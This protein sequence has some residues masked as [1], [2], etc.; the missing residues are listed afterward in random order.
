MP[1]L[2]VEEGGF[3][4][5]LRPSGQHGLEVVDAFTELQVYCLLKAIDE[6][7]IT[8]SGDGSMNLKLSD[9][10]LYRAVTLAQGGKL[11]SWYDLPSPSLP[12]SCC[13]QALLPPLCSNSEACLCN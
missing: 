11:L 6:A 8:K 13:L 3:A 9:E 12:T 7:N 4:F 2:V 10:F 1:P 5:P